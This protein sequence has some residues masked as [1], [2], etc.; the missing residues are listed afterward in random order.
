MDLTADKPDY[1]DTVGYDYL[2]C[3]TKYKTSVLELDC[4]SSAQYLALVNP[5]SQQ[6]HPAI[7]LW[8]I[9]GLASRHPSW[10]GFEDGDEFEIEDDCLPAGKDNPDIK[11]SP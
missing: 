10:G 9:F 2:T 5:R 8:S 3:G 1:T 4:W 7:G 6:R 11:V